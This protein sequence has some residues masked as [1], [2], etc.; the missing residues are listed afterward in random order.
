MNREELLKSLRQANAGLENAKKNEIRAVYDNELLPIVQKCVVGDYKLKVERFYEGSCEITFDL[1]DWHKEFGLGLSVRYNNI[2]KDI[3]LNHGYLSGD[4]DFDIKQYIVAR[5]K[6]IGHLWD[7]ESDL[8]DVFKKIN[9][10]ENDYYNARF[11]VERQIWDIED[12]IKTEKRNE[13]LKRLVVGSKWVYTY[14][15]K[16]PLTITKITP[17]M[18]FFE[19]P[20][21]SYG[22]N[23]NR[24]KISDMVSDLE[25]NQLV[26]YK[27]EK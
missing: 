15:P 13:A 24:A 19:R 9:E 18:I 8:I 14:A 5:D 26:E 23:S 4:G 1:G 10:I 21:Q 20:Y 6:I 25:Y 12:K 7:Y 22:D 27:E 2:R 17:K 16:R 11:K 3:E